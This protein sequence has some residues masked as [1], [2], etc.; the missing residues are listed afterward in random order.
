M[1]FNRKKEK[2]VIEEIKNHMKKVYS[3]VE[4]MIITIEDYLDG[5]IKEAEKK[6]YQTHLFESEADRLRREII[7]HL[8][9]G[10]FFPAI[11]EDIINYVAKQDKIADSAESCCDFIITQKPK[12]PEKFKN[13]LINI[14]RLTKETTLPLVKST[15]EPYGKN[16]D[17]T[18]E[19]IH[20]VNTKEEETDTL[21]WHLT[22]KIFQSKDISLAEKMHLREFV[23]HIVH[24]SD[25][26]E[27]T[28]D[29]LDTVIIKE[30]I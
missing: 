10:A 7:S 28:A 24:I 4:N 12:V 22:E 26:A 18:R 23:F 8:Y 25:L 21:E 14:A 16:S 15:E 6:A 27:D 11:R 9:E 3:S 29:M 30:S 5:N 1:I 13:D 19:I 17:K 2:K 20:M